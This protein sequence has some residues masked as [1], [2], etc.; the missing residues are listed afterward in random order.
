MSAVIIRIEDQDRN[1]ELPPE[2]ASASQ[3]Q[4]YLLGGVKYYFLCVAE[5]SR[6]SLI[7]GLGYIFA[8]QIFSEKLARKIGA[9]ECDSGMASMIF[10]LSKKAELCFYFIFFSFSMLF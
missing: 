6:H 5:F 10:F 3:P 1:S 7:L 8:V 9:Y 2:Q 4:R